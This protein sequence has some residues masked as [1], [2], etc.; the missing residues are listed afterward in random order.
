M[1]G[2][3]IDTWKKRYELILGERLPKINFTDIWVKLFDK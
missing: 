1:Y 3:I 2:L